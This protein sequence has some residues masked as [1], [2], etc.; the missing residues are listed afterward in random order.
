MTTV[1]LMGSTRA[2]SQWDKKDRQGVIDPA[3]FLG[4]KS[5]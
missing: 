2:A 1:V 3:L 5:V 4:P